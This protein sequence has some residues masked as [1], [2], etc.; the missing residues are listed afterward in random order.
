[1]KTLNARLIVSDF[2]GTLIDSSHTVP[3]EVKS[4]I[5]EYVSAGG[6]FAVCTGRMLSSILPR[7]RELGLKGLVIAY[8]GTVIAEIESGKL[9]R[10]GGLTVAQSVEIIKK[11]EQT[12]NY[13]NAYADEILYTDIPKDNKYLKLYESIVG[14]E[15]VGVVGERLSEYIQR[16]NLPCQKIASLV[17]KRSRNKLYRELANAFGD[18][19]DVTYSADVLVEVSPLGDDK[20]AALEFLCNHYNIPAKEAVAIGDSLNDLSMLKAAGT[21][22]AVANADE[23]L[24]EQADVITSSNDEAA[25]AKV[26]KKYG[27]KQV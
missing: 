14:V 15:A 23:A 12:G 22:V 11:I 27:F 25:V 1:M 6:I 8:Q 26:I 9:I 3:D 18:R 17:H 7:V 20:G 5:S 13:V 21:G 19:Y 24:K 10:C 16:N 2:D 4:A